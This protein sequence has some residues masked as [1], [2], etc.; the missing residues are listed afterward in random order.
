MPTIS[1]L[2][3]ASSISAADL[4]P[5]SQAGAAHSVSVGALLAQT[6]PAIII[7]SPSLLGRFSIG[8][9]GPDAIVL[10][11]GL[12]LNDGTLSSGDFNLASL[13]VQTVLSPTDQIVVTS[14][15]A[16]QLVAVDQ[17]RGLF[18]AG[19]NIIIDANGVISTSGSGDG[20]AYSLTALSPIVALAPEDLVGV[21][22]NGQ[23]HT[24]SYASFLDGLTIDLAQQALIATDSDTF[25]VAQTGNVMLRQTLGALWPWITE[26]LP[27]WK[28]SVIELS[29]N[30]TLDDTIHNNAILVCSNS[31]VVS[32][33]TA[34][35]SSG[36]SCELI[37]AS[38]G[39]V[40]LFGNVLTSN[41]SSGL[42]PSQ[43]GTIQCVT[44]SGGTVVFASISAGSSAT[45]APGQVSGLAA[46][47]V[48]S[49]SITLSWSAPTSGGVVSAY[50]VQYRVTGT[51][52]WLPGGQTSGSQNLTLSGLAAA[53]SYDLTIVAVNNIGSG[54][55]SA[56]LTIITATSNPVPGAP[57]AVTISNITAN[58][59]TCSWTAPS[60]GGSGILYG[61]QYRVAGQTAWVSAA[62]SL[63][64]TTIELSNLLPTTSYNIQV[65]ASNS[66]GSGLPSAVVTVETAAAIG[67]VSN[68]TWQ[69]VPTGSFAHGAGFIGVNAEVTPA[70]APIQFGFS[71]S[72]ISPPTS[73]TAGVLV[74]TNLWGQYVP[75]PS[76][77]GS[78]Y[79]W[80]EGTD[81]S[82]PTVYATPFTV[83]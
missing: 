50:S 23:D 24:I 51:A 26:K 48:D 61:V 62:S 29:V 45:V 73:W 34:E 60:L 70:T 77:A 21:S 59:M 49:T 82:C 79:P 72:S 35:I 58:S 19:S 52:P 2:P 74:N 15:E 17:I 1:Q 43:C 55:I 75:T 12:L 8:P 25:W 65:T 5:I 30:T 10:G 54:P 76:S 36:F 16:S 32:A 38:S 13:P 81:G 39:T 53:T 46:S 69:L 14:G 68:I 83:T 47:S 42:M 57:T 64:A 9:G 11:D 37:N 41:G 18:T 66:G 31:I 20:T 33:V 3:S 6:Q 22:Q 4:V 63:S 78:W 40:S 71:T 28:R 44:Y 67:L 56:V 27:L 7:D 80:A